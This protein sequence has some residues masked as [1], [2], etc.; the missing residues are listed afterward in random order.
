MGSAITYD[1]TRGTKSGEE[2]FKKFANNSGIIGGERF[3]FINP[4]LI[5]FAKLGLSFVAAHPVATFCLDV[6]QLSHRA[7][8]DPPLQ[9]CH[10]IFLAKRYFIADGGV[11]GAVGPLSC[12]HSD[13]VGNALFFCCPRTI[14]LPE[15]EMALFS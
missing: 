10:S 15:P 8:L 11:L 14:A 13:L 1:C 5:R 6:D 12:W 2:S 9:Y 3:R 7:K 4:F